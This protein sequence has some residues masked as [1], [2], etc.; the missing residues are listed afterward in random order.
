[1][2]ESHA[3]N[4]GPGWAGFLKQQHLGGWK[5]EGKR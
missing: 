1:M 2:M 3:D 5:P 4:G